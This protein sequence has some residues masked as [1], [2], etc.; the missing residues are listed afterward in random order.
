MRVHDPSLPYQA[1]CRSRPPASLVALCSLKT[2]SQSSL[3]GYRPAVYADNPVTSY[4]SPA[5]FN[6]R[7]FYPESTYP[8]H[9]GIGYG[10]GQVYIISEIGE[11]D[12]GN[13]TYKWTLQN[14]RFW[15]IWRP[16]VPT[17][18]PSDPVEDPM[19][20]IRIRRAFPPTGQVE[21]GLSLEVQRAKI[22]AAGGTAR[23]FDLARDHRGQGWR[24]R[25]VTQ[26]SRYDQ[27]CWS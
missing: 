17:I 19:I 10:Q 15:T 4:R 11:R 14:P 3:H 22:K 24:K 18:A 8:Q 21:S 12:S 16:Q 1:R 2:Q 13:L 7:L 25:E 26:S 23:L 27:S 9:P 20:A 5:T 6:N